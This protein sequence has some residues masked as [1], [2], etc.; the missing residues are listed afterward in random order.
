M[1]CAHC[2]GAEK[3][4]S[5]RMA[6]RE[7]REYQMKGPAKPTRLLIEAI[8]SADVGG[9]TLLDIGGGVGDIVNELLK[10]GVRRAIEVDASSAYLQ[11]A[12][13]EAERQGH[14]D[15]ISYHHG[16]FVVLASQL[17]L[18]DLVTLD[19]VICCYPDIQTLVNLSAVHA[20][21]LNGFVIPR[22]TWWMRVRTGLVNLG[23]Y[24]Q[25][26]PFRTFLHPTRDVDAVLRANGFERRYYGK[27]LLSQVLV[28]ARPTA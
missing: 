19:K 8:V 20:T 15:R 24:L 6:H 9:A 11:V 21:K 2:Q 28:Y 1:Q 27:T 25:R 4:F 10:V 14:A 26:N 12:R 18:A 3:T 16:D 5:Q 7:L 23:L 17:P 13:G 22:D